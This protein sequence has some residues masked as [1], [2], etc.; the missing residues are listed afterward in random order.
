MNIINITRV[1]KRLWHEYS[2][3]NTKFQQ[4]NSTLI[5]EKE[6]AKKNQD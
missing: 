2:H 1:L 4:Q 3:V 5:S 6:E